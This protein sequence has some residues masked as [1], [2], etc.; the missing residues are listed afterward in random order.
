MGSRQ[1]PLKVTV[2]SSGDLDPGS[3]FFAEADSPP[4]V[5]AGAVA[6]E[7]LRRRIGG[8]GVI[9]PVPGLKALPDRLDL[10][11]ILADL[12][13][14]GVGR[15][16][17]EGGSQVLGQFLAGGLA[18][19]FLLAVAPVFVADE[20]APRLL[21]GASAVVSSCSWPWLSVRSGTW[22]CSGTC[23]AG[24]SDHGEPAELFLRG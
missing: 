10:E 20:A 3:R 21:A 19:E 16:M 18:D 15:L 9:V 7:S 13:G 8:T 6:A 14:R 4:L 11:W 1:N 17:V 2:T 24:R 12:A 5:Y 23:L 22:P